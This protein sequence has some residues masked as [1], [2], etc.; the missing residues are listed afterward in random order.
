MK[1]NS[2]FILL[3]LTLV[4]GISCSSRKYKE[5]Q[6]VLGTRSVGIIEKRGLKFRD[7]NKNGKL[8]KYEDW[9]LTAEERSR[10]LLSKMSVE[11]KAGLMMINTLNM[12]GT[13]AAEASGGKLSASDLTEGAM[14]VQG[15]GQFSGREGS[16]ERAGRTQGN[17][18]GSS[19]MT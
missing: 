8:D 13:R 6:P 7:L 4:I 2:L 17:R 12:V 11:E 1:T 16:R 10:D 15:G 18:A 19:G 9:R 14:P 5:L 3:S